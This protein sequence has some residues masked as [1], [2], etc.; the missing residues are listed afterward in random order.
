MKKFTIFCFVIVAISFLPSCKLLTRNYH[1]I[2]EEK[3]DSIYNDIE[4]QEFGNAP[5]PITATGDHFFYVFWSEPFVV[6]DCGL[7]AFVRLLRHY[8]KLYEQ[9]YLDDV[10]EL[11]KDPKFWRKY[12]IQ[13][14]RNKIADELVTKENDLKRAAEVRKS[15]TWLYNSE[16]RILAHRLYIPQKYINFKFNTG[17]KKEDEQLSASDRKFIEWYS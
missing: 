12:T 5:R 15:R 6:G 3:E 10:P 2:E 9:G 17:N 11:T 14:L 4:H 1:N 13:Q 16:L 7:Y 8:C